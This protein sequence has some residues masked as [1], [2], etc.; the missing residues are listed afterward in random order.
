M[1]VANGTT[2]E[3]LKPNPFSANVFVCHPLSLRSALQ[4]VRNAA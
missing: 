4:E 3:Y 1:A 2:Y